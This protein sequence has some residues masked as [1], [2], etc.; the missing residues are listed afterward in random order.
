V[1]GVLGLLTTLTLVALF[2]LPVW[3]EIAGLP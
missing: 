1:S 2:L 3:Y